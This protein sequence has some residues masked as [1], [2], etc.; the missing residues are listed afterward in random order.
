MCSFVQQKPASRPSRSWSRKPAGSNHGSRSRMRERVAVPAALLAVLR[1]RPVV[2]RQPGLLVGARH[3]RPGLDRRPCRRSAAAGASGCRRR[4]GR[5]PTAA[6]SSS[7]A[8]AASNTHQ[9]TRPPPSAPITSSAAPISSRP[10]AGQVVPVRWGDDQLEHP[11]RVGSRRLRVG[12][13]HVAVVAGD[14]PDEAVAAAVDEVEPEMVRERLVAVGAL[15]F[16][17]QVAHRRDG[18]ARPSARSIS[19]RRTPARVPAA[20]RLASAPWHAPAPRRVARAR[21]RGGSPRSTRRP[22]A[23]STTAT[24][25]SCWRRRSCRRRPPTSGSTW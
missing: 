4:P 1:E 19:S 11:R 17:E 7:C 22:S 2:D 6:A 16:G 12:D 20:G 9:S 5:S 18:A 10:I 3:E 21:S 24:R 8:G 23:S 15:G 14:H 25:S 13:R